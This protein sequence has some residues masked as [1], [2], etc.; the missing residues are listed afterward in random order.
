MTIPIADAQPG[1][2]LV[3]DSD[4]IIA[5]V[6]YCSEEKLCTMLDMDDR[7]WTWHLHRID[8]ARN[9]VPVPSA[10]RDLLFDW[11]KIHSGTLTLVRAAD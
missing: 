7:R 4:T 9:T 5:T 3:D 1:D 6:E 10:L 8:S 11:H 2:L